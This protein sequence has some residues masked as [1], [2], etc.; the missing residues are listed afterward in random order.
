MAT[1]LF[2]EIIFGPVKSRRLGVSLGI[3]LLPTERKI[4]NFN[5]IYCE[6]G[7]TTYTGKTSGSLPSR[8]EVFDALEHKLSDMKS[9][10]LHPDVLTYAGNGEPTLHPEFA[11]IIDDSIELRNKY[12][13][14]AR[15]AVLSN[16]TTIGNPKIREALIKV[17]QNI[18]KLDSAC[19]NTIQ[20][21]NQPFRKVKAKELIREL[22]QFNGN[23]IVQTLFLRGIYKGYAIDNTTPEEIGEWLKAIAEIRPREVMIYTISRDTPE[24]GQLE[25]IPGKELMAIAGMVIDLGIKTQVSD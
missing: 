1:F 22:K 16:A 17:D 6:C 14:K 25:K 12:F 15:I 19:D 10:N 3:N 5:C 24:G 23:L 11:G 4:C 21:H 13:P 20:I 7:W 2:D 9:K 18:L 8:K